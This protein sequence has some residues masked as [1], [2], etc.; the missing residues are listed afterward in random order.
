MIVARVHDV[1]EA[2]DNIK[3]AAILRKAGP[4][5]KLQ[6]VIDRRK[7]TVRLKSKQ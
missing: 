4:V 3:S 5:C 6:I 1:R 7:K 2:V